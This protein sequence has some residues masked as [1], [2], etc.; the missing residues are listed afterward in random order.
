MIHLLGHSKSP[1]IPK[2]TLWLPRML[3]FHGGSNDV[4]PCPCNQIRIH[5]CFCIHFHCF[6]HSLSPCPNPYLYP[7]RCRFPFHMIP[8]ILNS[9]VIVIAV[10]VISVVATVFIIAI[11]LRLYHHH[12]YLRLIETDSW[13]ATGGVDF[14]TQ[15]DTVVPPQRSNM[16]SRL[17]EKYRERSGSPG[18]SNPG[19]R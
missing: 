5:F 3:S 14:Q 1:T 8:A 13:Q 10:I 4:G 2:L 6:L 15:Y 16:L 12:L 19:P 18:C 17:Y 9:M 7:R 11:Y